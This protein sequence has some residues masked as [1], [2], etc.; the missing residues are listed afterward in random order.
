MCCILAARWSFV[1]LQ[2][3]DYSAVI[4]QFTTPPSYGSTVVTVSGI[5]KDNEILIANSSATFTHDETRKDDDT[6]W[7]AP[8]SV[9]CRWEG[10]TKDGKPVTAEASGSVEP[11]LDRIDVMAEVPGFV[12]AIVAQAAGTKPYIYQVNY[13]STL[14]RHKLT[15]PPVFPEIQVQDQGR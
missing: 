8:T 3:P 15:Q 10:K 11:R 4:M 14:L 1:N 9:T 6:D 7:P 2:S 13:L 5:A 12:K